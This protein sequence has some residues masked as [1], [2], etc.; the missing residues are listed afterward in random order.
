[1]KHFEA[2]RAENEHGDVHEEPH[3]EDEENALDELPAVTPLEIAQRI[4]AH[5]PKT[6]A[7]PSV[8][9]DAKAF[10]E[11]L[12]YVD[13]TALQERGPPESLTRLLEEAAISE[14]MDEELRQEML[15]N[16][17]ARKALFYMG[18]E[19][20]FGCFVSLSGCSASAR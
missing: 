3:H 13:D 15:D 5:T 11:C 16:D 4:R 1:M 9:K 7:V 8:I 12:K 19:R 20:E 14:K 18:H 10:H 6:D 2:H 17:D